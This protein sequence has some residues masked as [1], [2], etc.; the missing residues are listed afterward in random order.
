M[1]YRRQR[2]T[3]LPCLL[4]RLVWQRD[5]NLWTVRCRKRHGRR[6]RQLR[7]AAPRRR[8]ATSMCPALL[9]A[10]SGGSY[11]GN[12]SVA[13]IARLLAASYDI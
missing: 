4:T 9:L 6:S 3:P 13:E 5:P 2:I 8:A 11:L 7:R 10:K 1:E 12:P